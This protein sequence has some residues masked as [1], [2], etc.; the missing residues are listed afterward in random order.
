MTGWQDR[1]D[2]I[3]RLK[4]GWLDG[5]GLAP[6]YA[7]LRAA[8]ELL[9]MEQYEHPNR[10]SIYPA[11]DGGITLEWPDRSTDLK[12]MPDGTI[13][14]DEPLTEGT[15]VF[16][17]EHHETGQPAKRTAF[18]TRDRAKAWA[19]SWLVDTRARLGHPTSTPT[20]WFTDLEG[21]H[22]VLGHPGT[23]ITELELIR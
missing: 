23:S 13:E 21:V 14:V 15:A 10:P 16:L 3:A 22:R 7:A 6:T 1:L 18:A 5:S 4:D 8:A 2:H 11:P 17:L 19:A 20:Y 12:V 9:E